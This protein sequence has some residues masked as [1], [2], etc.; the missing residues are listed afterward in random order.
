MK[1]SQACRLQAKVCHT[2]TQVRSEGAGVP[3]VEGPKL[4]LPG[5]Q[6]LWALSLQGNQDTFA[7]HLCL[8]LS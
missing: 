7:E 6:L 5:T 8:D 1:N 3:P 4:I 2:E